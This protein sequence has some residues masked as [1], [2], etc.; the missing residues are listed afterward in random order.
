MELVKFNAMKNAV[1]ECHSIDEIANIRD[2]AEAY[3]YAMVQAKESPEFIKKA[4][5]I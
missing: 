5:E 1:A 2:K 3:R 4:S